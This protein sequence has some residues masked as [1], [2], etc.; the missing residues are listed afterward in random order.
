LAKPANKKMGLTLLLFKK[1][2][3]KHFVSWHEIEHGA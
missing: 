3:G 1:S 2:F